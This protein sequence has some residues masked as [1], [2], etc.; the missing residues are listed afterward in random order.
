MDNGIDFLFVG[1]VEFIPG[2]VFEYWRY[3]SASKG[4]T[5]HG[6][7]RWTLSHQLNQVN[8]KS[9]VLKRCCKSFGKVGAH[10]PEGAGD[11]DVYN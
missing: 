8:I 5:S 1:G 9:M 3:N 4:I 7:N 11:E 2:N 10:K 6:V